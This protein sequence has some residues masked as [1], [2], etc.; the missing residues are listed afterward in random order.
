MPRSSREF[1]SMRRRSGGSRGSGRLRLLQPAGER[2][3]LL[4]GFPGRGSG[5]Q[6]R[7]GA[8]GLLQSP[9][10]PLAQLPQSLADRGPGGQDGRLQ[11][12]S[13][14]EDAVGQFQL[15]FPRDA[16]SPRHVA[17]VDADVIPG[18]EDG[19]QGIG[20]RGRRLVMF[21]RAL[22][23]F[24]RK[25]PNTAVGPAETSSRASTESALQQRPA[26][27]LH[28]ANCGGCPRGNNSAMPASR[29]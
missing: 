12:L 20:G 25:R 27:R 23:L 10:A 26:P 1:S 2:Q 19:K 24:H 21:G 22:D 28:S 17:Q 6:R 16:R 3:E 9:V 18:G 29:G 4:L 13:Q 14:G 8:S 15:L 11:P 5:P 7:S